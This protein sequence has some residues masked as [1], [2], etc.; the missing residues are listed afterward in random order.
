MDQANSEMLEVEVSSTSPFAG[1]LVPNDWITRKNS[2]KYDY[3]SRRIG[4]TNGYDKTSNQSVK[5]VFAGEL[6]K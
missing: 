3:S 4:D 2:Y 5:L 6:M 1:Q